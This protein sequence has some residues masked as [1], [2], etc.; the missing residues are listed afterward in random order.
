MY[1]TASD[2][3]TSS[4]VVSPDFVAFIGIAAIAAISYFL[5]SK[6]LALIRAFVPL[7]F[8]PFI[9]T[10]LTSDNTFVIEVLIIKA[11]KTNML[12]SS[13][14]VLDSV[15][16]AIAAHYVVAFVVVWWGLE[17]LNVYRKIINK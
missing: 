11:Y 9:Y 8:I 3:Y 5:L 10:H 15:N 6:K 12:T 4:T 17:I 2:C 16:L 1:C 13:N 14:I 7:L